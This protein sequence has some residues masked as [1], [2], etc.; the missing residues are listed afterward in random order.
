MAAQLP[1]SPI[2]GS[3]AA[4]ATSPAL[5]GPVMPHEPPCIFS[6]LKSVGLW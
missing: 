4:R 2:P 6:L 5:L 1:P 3:L